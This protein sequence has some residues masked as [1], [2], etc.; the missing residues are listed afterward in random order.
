MYKAAWFLCLIFF[1]C[2]FMIFSFEVETPD[3]NIKFNGWFG[4]MSDD[5]ETWR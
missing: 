3:G 1:L 2:T 5:L 4:K